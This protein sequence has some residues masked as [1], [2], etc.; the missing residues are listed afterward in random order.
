MLSL[1]FIYLSVVPLSFAFA[2]SLA[3]T[4]VLSFVSEHA[5][6]DAPSYGQLP[7]LPHHPHNPGEVNGT[8]YEFLANNPKFVIFQNSLPID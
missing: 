2:T 3:R 7:I 6:Y 1:S 5:I 8:I 4:N